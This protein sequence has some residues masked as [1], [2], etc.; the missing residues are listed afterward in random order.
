VTQE[1]V[2][3]VESTLRSH[4]DATVAAVR[5]LVSTVG[6]RVT[7]LADRV[8][9]SQAEAGARIDE[10]HAEALQ[11]LEQRHVRDRHRERSGTSTLGVV[12]S[13]R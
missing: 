12:E 2:A 10:K 3:A 13:D 1:R 11:L 6:D 9:A 5:H 8:V 4:G 7:V